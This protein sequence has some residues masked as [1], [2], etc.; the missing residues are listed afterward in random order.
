MNTDQKVQRFKDTTLG[1]VISVDEY[2]RRLDDKSLTEPCAF[3]FRSRRIFLL[4]DFFNK[5]GPESLYWK[6]IASLE[7]FSGSSGVCYKNLG[8]R[9]Q[10]NFYVFFGKLLDDIVGRGLM[11]KMEYPDEIVP[12]DYL[13]DGRGIAVRRCPEEGDSM[14]NPMCNFYY[15]RLEA[16]ALEYARA[17][18][19]GFATISRAVVRIP[20]SK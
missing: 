17:F 20:C 2:Q 3:D 1:R 7:L 8:G 12:G 18:C 19:S 6:D 11:S 4:E 10:N 5:T 15:P 9:G 13:I 14:G 16:D